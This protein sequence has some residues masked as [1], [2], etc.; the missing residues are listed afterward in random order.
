LI[1]GDL[2]RANSSRENFEIAQ[3]LLLAV[4]DFP[5]ALGNSNNSVL[6]SAALK[7][8][9]L[10]DQIVVALLNGFRCLISS[11]ILRLT[12][13]GPLPAGQLPAVSAAAVRH[14]GAVLHKNNQPGISNRPEMTAERETR[15]VSNLSSP[16]TESMVASE[17][18]EFRRPSK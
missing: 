1:C 15:R 4:R 16:R 7:L 10:A 8:C 14:R 3:N 11:P 12:P 18:A 2:G 5:A 17:T 9:Q 6:S 13:C